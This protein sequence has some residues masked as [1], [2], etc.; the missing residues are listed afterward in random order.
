MVTGEVGVNITQISLTVIDQSVVQAADTDGS[1]I[2]NNHLLLLHSV[3][4]K[5][6]T[7][8][9]GR[10]IEVIA[11]RSWG[12]ESIVLR[13]LVNTLLNKR[14]LSI[15]RGSGISIVIFHQVLVKEII[16]GLLLV[17]LGIVVLNRDGDRL[18]IVVIIT[19]LLAKLGVNLELLRRLRL[20][21][22]GVEVE[23]SWLHA[24]S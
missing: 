7:A 5:W 16:L 6:V 23:L 19:G 21:I 24:L 15:V 17:G 3:G 22:L 14:G 2:S 8:I 13:V 9:V 20:L 1:T 4:L 10:S 12:S 11:L 18:V